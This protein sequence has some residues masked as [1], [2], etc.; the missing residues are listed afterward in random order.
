[1]RVPEDLSVV[2]FDNVVVGEVAAVP[3]T[4]IDSRLEEIGVGATRVLLDR[5]LGRGSS[6]P[7]QQVLAPALVVRASSGPA[8]TGTPRVHAPARA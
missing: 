4:T 3:V 8:S 2:G 1:V 7:V 6:T 5:L